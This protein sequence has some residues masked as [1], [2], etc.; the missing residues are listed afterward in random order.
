MEKI[1]QKQ[2]TLNYIQD[3]GSITSLEAFKDLGCTRLSAQI[4]LLKKDGYKFKK[5]KE[6]VKN[7]W[8][9]TVRYDRYFLDDEDGAVQ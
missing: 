3:F 2:R 7:R 8:G 4:Y 6:A 9:D 5:E 1:S